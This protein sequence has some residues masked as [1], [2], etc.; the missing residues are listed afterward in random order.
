V[1]LLKSFGVV[2]K[3]GVYLIGSLFFVFPLFPVPGA[4]MAPM[5]E[6]MVFAEVIHTDVEYSPHTDRARE[7]GIGGGKSGSWTVIKILEARKEPVVGTDFAADDYCTDFYHPDKEITLR[8]EED[9]GEGS[10]IKGA[11]KVSGDEFA[12]GYNMDKIETIKP[13][14]PS[15]EG[16]YSYRYVAIFVVAFALLV[17]ASVKFLF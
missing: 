5:P 16:H 4:P 2:K 9:Y 8:L 12:V 6:C 17:L 11:I 3:S 15:T 7:K 1:G 10:I 14:G 13:V